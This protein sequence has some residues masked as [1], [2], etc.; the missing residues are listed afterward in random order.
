MGKLRITADKFAERVSKATDGR[1]SIVKETYTGTRNKVTAYCNMHKI[2][3]EVNAARELYRGNTN[4]PECIN[5]DRKTVSRN[6]IKSWTEVYDSFIQKYGNKFS[7]DDKSYSGTKVKMKVHCNDC[8]EDFEITPIHHLK[9]NN[10]GCPNCHKTKIVKCSKCGKEIVVDRYIGPNFKI[11][12]DEC[13][14][15][16]RRTNIKIKQCK[17]CGN[18]IKTGTKCNNDF[19]NEHHIQTFK[20]LIKYFG[21]DKNKLGTEEAEDMLYDM[22]WNQHMTSSQ[23][24][25]FFN[26]YDSAHLINN[27]F[28]R[29][30]IPV[31]TLSQS[32][33]E[34]YKNGIVNCQNSIGNSYKSTQ[35]TTWNNNKVFLRSS[36]E[37]DYAKYLDENKITYEVEKLRIEY[38]DSQNNE[39]RIAIPDFYLPEINTIVEIKSTWTLDVVNMIDKVK[40]YKENGYGFKL[41]LEHKETDI[42]SLLNKPMINHPNISYAYLDKQCKTKVGHNKWKWMN[43]GTENR[44]VTLDMIEDYIT[45]GFNFGFL[46]K[47]KV[48]HSEF[49]S[50]TY[51]LEGSCSVQLS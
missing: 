1:I 35:H 50:E 28:Y 15:K 10:G 20:T 23:I 8:G 44:K 31:K 18:Y 43:N 3:F 32:V 48:H 51:C 11:Y 37:L 14:I 49:E 4:C 2:Y 5:E 33:K 22:Y 6:K 46:I 29:L 41:I 36:Y 21:Y 13:K 40:A 7:Y 26:Y 19:C 47:N 17:I 12:C 16:L 30:N 25:N 9:Y 34:A 38:Y 45:N 42:Y 27:V 24:T 39:T